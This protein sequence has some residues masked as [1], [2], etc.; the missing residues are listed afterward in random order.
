MAEVRTPPVHAKRVDDLY[1]DGGAP[2]AF[3]YYRSGDR[4]PAGMIYLCPCGCGA[5]NALRFRPSSPEHP[6]WEW[7]GNLDAPTLLPS[8]HRVGHWHGWLKNGVWESV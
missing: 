6:S 8:V 5:S 3:E 4:F 2:G 7:D 1:E